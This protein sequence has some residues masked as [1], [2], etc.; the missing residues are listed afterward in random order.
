MARQPQS[1]RAALGDED[2]R[3][4]GARVSRHT[5]SAQHP[6]RCQIRDEHCGLEQ[7]ENKESCNP[8]ACTTGLL[9][10]EFKMLWRYLA[11]MPARA[12][13]SSAGEVNS[14]QLDQTSL[15]HEQCSS[16]W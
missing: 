13:V 10:T 6:D 9:L 16:G 2:S 12:R 8:A 7:T 3:N 15:N 4:L 5:P 1:E 14:P 11:K